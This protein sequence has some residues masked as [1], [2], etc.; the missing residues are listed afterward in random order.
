M[1]ILYI[2]QMNVVAYR[3]EFQMTSRKLLITSGGLVNQATFQ[4]LTPL[5]TIFSLCCHLKVFKLL[6]TYFI[7]FDYKNIKDETLIDGAPND[8]VSRISF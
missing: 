7:D 8:D 1:G 5:H 2:L 6:I 3:Q 4:G